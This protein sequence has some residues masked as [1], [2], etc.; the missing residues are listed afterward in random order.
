[1]MASLSDLE[2][3]IES[4]SAAMLVDAN[5]EIVALK[6]QLFDA[7]IKIAELEQRR[8]NSERF[9]MRHSRALSIIMASAE[10]ALILDPA[11]RNTAPSMWPTD[12]ARG[13]G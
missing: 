1:M 11:K 7:R 8:D 13:V 3:S 4:A 9:Y 5:R 6:A 12:D 2:I 10:W